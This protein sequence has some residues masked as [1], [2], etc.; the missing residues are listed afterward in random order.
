MFLKRLAMASL[1]VGVFGCLPKEDPVAPAL[2]GSGSFVFRMAVAP[3][4]PFRKL[5]KSAELDVSAPDMSPIRHAL[6][7]TDTSVEGRVDRIPAGEGRTFLVRVFDSAG[8]ECYRGSAVGRIKA[9]STTNIAITI[10]RSTGAVVI[11]GTVDEGGDS[12][13]GRDS[14][15]SPFVKDSATVFLADFNRNTLDA[16]SGIKGTV[17]GGKFADAVFGQGL[18]FDSTLNPKTGYRFENTARINIATGTLEAL[19]KSEGSS[20][21]FMHIID[22]SWL[23]GLTVFNGKVAVDFGTTWW[24]SNYSLPPQKWTYLCGSFDGSKIRIFADGEQVDS[25]FY[26]HTGMDTT[27]GL[28]IGNAYDDNFNIPFI[29]RIDEVRVSK[30][31]RTPQ[32]IRQVWLAIKPELP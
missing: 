26:F 7:I 21:G 8:T 3:D 25:A 31:A 10:S 14:L 5:A 24:Y 12:T 15:I 18:E 16:V 11:N 29:G 13:G 28:G 32:E 22:K 2:D 1:L 19:V 23:Y 17:T 4:S 6:M 30:R 20:S 27:W 9:D